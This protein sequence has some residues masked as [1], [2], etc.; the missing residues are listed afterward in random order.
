[1]DN[2]GSVL[3]EAF[4]SFH[5]DPAVVGFSGTLTYK[6][7][8][9]GA[10][11]VERALRACGIGPN[12]PVLVPVGNEPRDAA[13]LIGVWSAGGVAV[14]VARGGPESWIAAIR[15]QTGAR[16]SVTNIESD[17]ATI[18]NSQP[19]APRA[20]LDGAAVVVLTSGSTGR[21]KGVVLSHS[22]FIGKLQAID[23][24]LGFTAGTRALLVL[25]ITFVFGLWV[26]L[27]SLL[28]GGQVFM[29][30]RFNPMLALNAIRDE[31]ISDVALVPTMMRKWLALEPSVVTPLVQSSD[32]LR[33]LTG[34]EPLGRELALRMS[35]FMPQAS[36]VDIYGLTE[37]CSSD[38]Y[39]MPAERQEF[40][41]T[42]GR[43]APQVQFR[44]AD[45]HGSPLAVGETGELQ[46]K[47]PFVMKGYLDEPELTR[48][49]FTDGFFQT[50][51]LARRRHDGC[52][53][54]VD[55]IKDL[56]N[57]GGAK[58][59]PLELDDILLEHP[60]V[61]AALTTGV[62][63][64]L[65]GECIHTLVVPRSGAKLDESGLREW[66][67]TRVERFKQP[68]FYHFASELPTGRTGKVDRK[69]LRDQLLRQT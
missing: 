41:G 52:V 69:A 40:G 63:D 36:I 30:S 50:G 58:V 55:R 3:L 8:I 32:A 46:I 56:I 47:S 25:Q 26:L 1:M 49:A 21:P 16:F 33:L 45:N 68:D 42:I 15:A 23:S 38:F 54:L 9:D 17:F 35:T 31:Q 61:A 39:L 27:L 13:A 11:A 4:E 14:P 28:K 19:P 64:A 7:L 2:L 44:I 53:E 48:A 12:E 60:A 20:L 59:S 18:L 29:H 62:P 24:V 43:P 6:A 37:T 22:A 34:G 66:M 65:I 5:K 57:R 51:D 67:A 10:V